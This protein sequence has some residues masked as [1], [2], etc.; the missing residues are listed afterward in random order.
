MNRFSRVNTIWRKE[1]IDTLRD[2]RTVIAMVLVPMVL[3]P[4]LM[5]GSLQAIEVQV[6]S[7]RQ[8]DTDAFDSRSIRTN[9]GVERRFSRRLTGT[10]GVSYRLPEVRDITGENRFALFAVPVG[11][12]YDA[13]D[14]LYWAFE[15]LIPPPSPRIAR[16]VSIRVGG[17]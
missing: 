12:R 3:Y 11:A 10:A 5:L 4:A 17:F 15:S 14:D 6:G 9:L 1:L 13:S 2:R 7:L 16:S 8:E